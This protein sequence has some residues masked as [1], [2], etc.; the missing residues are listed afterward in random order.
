ME[1]L[2]PKRDE[3]EGPLVIA[4]PSSE[5]APAPYVVP[6]C[7]EEAMGEALEWEIRRFFLKRRDPSAEGTRPALDD[8]LGQSCPASR[9]ARPTCGSDPHFSPS[10]AFGSLLS[11]P[12]PDRPPPHP[13]Q[14]PWK[15]S[16]K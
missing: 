15:P 16:G 6:T 5:S 9:P 12:Q 2:W 3:I 14:T 11:R 10:V 8:L 4:S 13:S 7:S 1:R